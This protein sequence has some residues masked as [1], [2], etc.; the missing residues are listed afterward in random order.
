MSKVVWLVNYY[1]MP[2]ELESRLRTI[3]FAQYLKESGVE[4]K[5]ISS[6]IMHNKNVDLINDKQ[7]FIEKE[8]NGI[9][10]IHIKSPSYKSNGLKRFYSL[11]VFHIKLHLL[12]NRFRTPSTIVHT[13]LPPFGFITVLTARKLNAKYI[14][15]V[16]DLWPESFVA[17]GLMNKRNP[18]IYFLYK[19]EKW[20][21][22]KADS[23]VFSMEGGKDYIIS[24]RWDTNNQGPIDLSKVHYINN[25]VDL[26]DFDKHKNEFTLEDKDLEDPSVFK[27][28]YLGSIR[29]ANDIKR[30]IDAAHLLVND[31]SIRFLIYG[32][33]S[34]RNNLEEYC[35][36]NGIVNVIFKEKWIDPKY[37][38]YVLSKSDLNILNYQPNQIFRFGGSQS[39]LFQYL[40][41]GKP[42][43]S[44]LE[45]GYCPINKHSLGVAKKFKDEV[46]YSNAILS[47]KNLSP[48]NY[49][50]I[51]ARTRALASEY[52]YSLLTEKLKPIL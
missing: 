46:E 2:P 34:D 51:C 19:I 24:K 11:F 38:P 8:Y 7:K 17:F 36:K 23:I 48:V 20:I 37:V 15:E 33:G 13:C 31:K 14:A 21:Y 50:A 16:L 9:E 32:D 45:M 40:A 3:K 52:D 25:G 10:F 12:R 18:L 39:K 47:I 42:I 22:K 44:N 43:C 5:I 4:V 35:N 1:A 28:I 27:V 49:Q 26:N 41:S 29:L 6:S 30:L